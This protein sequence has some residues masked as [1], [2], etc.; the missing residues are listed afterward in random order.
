MWIFLFGFALCFSHLSWCR[1]P[2]APSPWAQ[3]VCLVHPCPA[4]S[5]HTGPYTQHG[6]TPQIL[7]LKG[8]GGVITRAAFLPRNSARPAQPSGHLL[9]R[10]RR[11]SR[12]GAA[13]WGTQPLFPGPAAAERARLSGFQDQKPQGQE[14]RAQPNPL[15]G[16]Q[17]LS[18]RGERPGREGGEKE[19]ARNKTGHLQNTV[20]GTWASQV[21][22]VIKNPPA[23]AG[24]IPGPGRFPWKRGWHPTPVFLPGESPW[25][26]EP[27][28]LQSMGAT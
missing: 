13:A 6:G 10:W 22:L 24:S 15:L 5:L 21:A 1:L 4:N 19:T 20:V 16:S 25:A 27:G 18:G 8:A 28:G 7:S 26:E 3:G 23:D 2:A 9:P 11:R 12:P 14:P 17:F